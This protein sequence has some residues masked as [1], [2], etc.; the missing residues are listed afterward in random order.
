MLSRDATNTNC[1]V[2]GLTRSGLEL[3][4]SGTRGELTNHYTADAIGNEK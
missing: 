1:L 3:A 4:I 2:F